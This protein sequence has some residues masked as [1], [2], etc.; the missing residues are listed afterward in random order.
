MSFT[1]VPFLA[2]FFPICV[3][4]NY[5]LNNKYRNSF[6]CLAS[7][8]FYAW[9]GVR[10][11]IL[12]ALSSLFAY[13]MGLLMARTNR[14]W[15]KKGLLICGMVVHVG[16]L[17][18]YKY[19]FD[20]LS[21]ISPWIASVAGHEV[22]LMAQSP[23]LPLGISFYTFSLLSYLLDVYWGICE[24]Q[25][26]YLNIWLFVAFFPKV[27]Q[28]PIMR[29]ADFEKQLYD[30]PVDLTT[31]NG[32]LERFIKGMFKKVMIADQL[33]SLVTYSFSNLNGVG[34]V[35]AWISIICYMLQLYYDFSGYSDMAIGL[36]RMVGFTI[37][38]NFDHPY[39]SSSVA[40]YWRRWHISLG[41]WFRD[42]VYT[43]CIRSFTQKKWAKK[44]KKPFLVCD[45]LALVV[46]WTLTGIWHG[47][48]LQFLAYGLW[49]CMFI[50]LERLRDDHRKKLKKQG[51][52]KTLKKS[53]IQIVADHVV[54][55]LAVTIGMVFFRANSL[56]LALQYLKRMFIWN[57]TDGILI[58]HEFTD[59]HVVFL[60][61]ALLFIFPIYERIKAAIF[62]H[63]KG[64]RWSQTAQ[65]GYKLG[66]IV[67]F[68]IAFSY[69][70]SNGYTPFLYEIF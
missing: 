65:F 62:D 49:F 68:L 18:Y 46:T 50:V 47:S 11:L 27:V 59:Y 48:G 19:L 29:Y 58:L 31:L 23:I 14:A 13:G 60:A 22:I 1:S 56:A 3:L 52:L 10:F 55:M 36:A 45:A 34:T 66:L 39:M 6:L 8:V 7:L 5:Y 43:P 44:L 30:R 24:A 37:P 64:A 25:K 54:T 69:M 40:E 15:L 53:G 16:M 70:V 41:A 67:V 51:K 21:A 57:T 20:I 12:M 32:G 33:Q 28:G 9:C 35:P 61:I 42:Y 2:L 4:G 38:E 63:C 26:N 17:C